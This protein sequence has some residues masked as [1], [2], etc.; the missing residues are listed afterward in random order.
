[1]IMGFNK[2]PGAY[3]DVQY[4]EDIVDRLNVTTSDMMNIYALHRMRN[5]EPNYIQMKIKGVSVASFYSG[6]SFKHYVGRPDYAVTIFLSDDDVLPNDFEGMLRR[7]AHYILPKRADLDFEIM[8]K[9]EFDALQTFELDP[10]WE[11]IIEGE[12]SKIMTI[13]ADEDSLVKEGAPLAPQKDELNFDDQ[14]DQLEKDELKEQIKELQDMVREKQDKIR[15]L[16]EKIAQ[17]ASAEHG[18]GVQILKQQLD[19]QDKKLDD[20]SLKLADLAEKNAILMETVRKLTEM[21]MQQTEE[22]ERQGR[23]LLDDKKLLEEKNALIEELKQ[24]AGEATNETEASGAAIEELNTKIEEL[25]A[26]NKK[27]LDTITDL[28]LE[29]KNLKTKQEQSTESDTTVQKDLAEQIIELKKDLKVIRR[30][31]DH[32]KD[33]VKEKNLL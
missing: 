1:M 22:M 18:G 4:P 23:K 33:I 32:Y 30:E 26:R 3:V 10:Y 25:D 15:D 6:F 21:S 24:S 20:W 16:T 12:G 2:S 7:F 11:E 31:R 19:E 29:I 17:Q 9:E 5:M 13:Q 28:K 27:Y 8:F 14:F